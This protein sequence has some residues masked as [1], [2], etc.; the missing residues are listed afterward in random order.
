MYGKCKDCKKQM[1]CHKPMGYK[2]GFCETDFEPKE[3]AE[4][5]CLDGMSWKQVSSSEWEAIGKYGVFKIE[6]S[7]REFWAS[8]ASEDTSFRMPPK[9]KLSAAKEMCEN[10]D[11]W[12]TA[13]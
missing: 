4:A 12:E 2:F 13:S 8:Y 7:G 9:R 6:R 11:N 10:N 1:S 5:V 3:K